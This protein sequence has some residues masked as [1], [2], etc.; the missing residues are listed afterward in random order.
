MIPIPHGW[1]ERAYNWL[2]RKV[3]PARGLDL[4]DEQFD[5]IDARARGYQRKELWLGV[6]VTA[7]AFGL[8]TFLLAQLDPWILPPVE[9][10]ILNTRGWHRWVGAGMGAGV[11]ISLP[12]VRAYRRDAWSDDLETY[13]IYWET[14]KGHDP[15]RT[16]RYLL[17]ASVAFTAVFAAFCW[18]R[19]EVVDRNGIVFSVNPLATVH[20]SFDEVKSVE[21]YQALHA[22][23]GLVDTPN[24]R[25]TFAG[26]PELRISASGGNGPKGVKS[27]SRTAQYISQRSGVPIRHGTVRP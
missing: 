16:E 14:K 19:G 18:N 27:L 1:S 4:D 9:Q 2:L 24:L 22:P 5:R 15:V 6:S 12:F 20:R 10:P 26:G 17:F 7:A 25:V 13:R 3:A 23:F 11:L 21:L 8:S